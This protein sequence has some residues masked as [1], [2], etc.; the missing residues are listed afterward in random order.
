M[1][2]I[3]LVGAGLI[4]AFRASLWNLGADGQYLLAVAF[5]A[6]VGPSIVTALPPVIGWV[7]LA[8][9]GASPSGRRGRSS[10]ACSRRA[11]A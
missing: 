3:L 5:V 11:M 7:V 6:G 4:V 1:A 2:P 8:L 9:L 10:R